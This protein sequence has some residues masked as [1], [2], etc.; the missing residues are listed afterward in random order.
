MLSSETIQK[1]PDYAQPII[2]IRAWCV[3]KKGFLNSTTRRD[4]RWTPGEVKKAACDHVESISRHAFAGSFGLPDPRRKV[5]RHQAPQS[6]C[7]CGLYAFYNH[8]DPRFC[9]PL[10]SLSTLGG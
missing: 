7:S 2:G 8:R 6:G 5:L 4:E 3:D 10:T 9:T 1:A